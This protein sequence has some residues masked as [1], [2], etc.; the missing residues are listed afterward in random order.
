MLLGGGRAGEQVDDEVAAPRLAARPR[1][2]LGP[3]ERRVDLEH[4]ER[5]L[6]GR[7]RQVLQRAPA[8]PGA[9]LRRLALEVAHGDRQVGRLGGAQHVGDEAGLGGA[10]RRRGDGLDGGGDLLEQHAPI[11]PGPTD[12]AVRRPSR[13]RRRLS[14]SAAGDGI[15][16][17][18]SLTQDEAAARSALVSV[19]RYDVHLDLTGLQAGRTLRSD[20]TI[21]FTSRDPGAETFV[22][23]VADRLLGVELNGEQV[24]PAFD[25]ERLRLTGLAEQN[26]LRVRA[27]TDRTEQR[28]GLH[29]TVDPAD[30]EVYVWTTFEPDDARRVFACFDQPDLKAVFAFRVTA[31]EPWLVVHNTPGEAVAVEGADGSALGEWTFEE[32]PRLSTYVTAVCAGPFHEVRRRTADHDLSVLSRRSLRGFLDDQAEEVLDVTEQGLAWFAEH[33]GQPFPQRHY[34]QVFCPDYQGAMEN[35]GCVV[36]T[37]SMVFRTPPTAEAERPAPW[38]CCTRWPTCGSATW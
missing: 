6:L 25:G 10:R 34:A 9:P 29:R 4:G 30:G 5:R 18:A 14:V 22:D 11:L 16:G 7:P 8:Q 3:L 31:P 15:G 37:D 32:T 27:S 13:A 35:F 12:N 36:W 24:E 2:G 19:D 28:T 20:T 33:F 21:T 23:V 1:L 38:C 26:V 17:M